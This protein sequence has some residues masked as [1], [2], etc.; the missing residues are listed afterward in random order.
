MLWFQQQLYTTASMYV[1][2]LSN[3]VYKFTKTKG[4]LAICN[5]DP[6]FHVVHLASH[7]NLGCVPK[8][9]FLFLVSVHPVVALTK[10]I[11]SHAVWTQLGHATY[12]LNWA[13][14]FDHLPNIHR[15]VK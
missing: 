14:N 13:L 8:A 3:Q 5:M 15:S 6:I 2:G 7:Q 10:Y 1:P 9:Y 12:S 4:T 11:L